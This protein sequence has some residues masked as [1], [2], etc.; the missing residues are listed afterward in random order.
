MT[1]FASHA[2]LLAVGLHLAAKYDKEGVNETFRFAKM[3]QEQEV[4]E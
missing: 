1:Y 2:S 3:G 4:Y